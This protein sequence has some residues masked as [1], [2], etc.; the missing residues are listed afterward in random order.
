[1]SQESEQM[2]ISDLGL[3]FGKTCPEPLVQTE[4]RTL[5]LSSKRQSVSLS[6]MPLF[7]DMRGVD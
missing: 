2:D 4:E 1:M 7:L 5:E 6:R 3:W